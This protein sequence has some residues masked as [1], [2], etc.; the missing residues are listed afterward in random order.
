ARS[1]QGGGA[2]PHPGPD[3]VP[4]HLQ[5]RPP[6]HLPR[7]LRVGRPGCGVH[8]GDPDRHRAGRADLLPPRHLAHRLDVGALV[9]QAGVPRP[10]RCPDGLVH[11]P[12]LAADRGPR[13]AA[14]GRHRARLPQPMGDRDGPHRARH[15]PRHRR[16]RQRRRQEDRAPDPARRG[17]DGSRPGAGAHP[18]CLPQRRHHLHGSP[19]GLRARGGHPLRLPPRDPRRGRGRAVRAQGDTQRRQHL[20]LGPDHRRHGRVLRGRV[21]RHRLAAAL[22][23]DEVVH[24]VRGLPDRPRARHARAPEHRRALRERL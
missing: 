22:R 10:L 1:A 5:Q 15:R 6:A 7:A 21:R 20:R 23:L 12:R 8:G 24:A 13:R 11:H 18:R 14:Q 9:G 19:P 17:P 2:G 3:R 4:A 16:P